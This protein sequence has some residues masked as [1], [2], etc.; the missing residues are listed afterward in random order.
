MSEVTGTRPSGYTTPI[1]EQAIKDIND[2][3]RATPGGLSLAMLEDLSEPVPVSAGRTHQA[4]P[5]AP[6]GD[7]APPPPPSALDNL[8][9]LVERASTITRT[10]VDTALTAMLP[11]LAREPDEALVDCQ[12]RG[13]GQ[14]V[15]G[16]GVVAVAALRAL[17]KLRKAAKRTR[18]AAPPPADSVSAGDDRDPTG[19]YVEADAGGTEMIRRAWACM[20]ARDGEVPIIYRQAGRLVRVGSGGE[21]VEVDRDGLRGVLAQRAQWYRWRVSL[22]G[23][24]W[25]RMAFPPSELAGIMVSGAVA[26]DAPVPPLDVVVGV[27]YVDRAGEVVRAPGYDAGSR[28]LLLPH[29]LPVSEMPPGDAAALLQDWIADFPFATGGGAAHAVGL[30][31]TPLIRRMID[32]PVPPVLIEAPKPRSGKTLLAQALLAPVLGWSAVQ[33][34]PSGQEEQEK[35]IFASLLRAHPAT[36]LDNV[37]GRVESAALEMITTAYPTV[38]G[39]PLGSSDEREVQHLTQW[40]LTT[41]NGSFTEDMIGRLV[42]I[43]IDWKLERPDLID[44]SG[45]RHP[46]IKDYTMKNRAALLS[47]LLSLVRAWVKAGRP[48]PACPAKGS[49]EMWRLVTGGILQHAGFTGFLEGVSAS[50]AEI[51]EWRAIVAVW[52]QAHGEGRVRLAKLAEMCDSRDLAQGEMGSGGDHARLIRLGAALRARAGQVFEVDNGLIVE[53]FGASDEEALDVLTRNRMT[54]DGGAGRAPLAG[55]W[56]IQPVRTIVGTKMYSLKHL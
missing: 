46:D 17:A 52:A 11:D 20:E 13:I 3:H 40:V 7:S 55:T 37:R 35:T 2:L 26:M 39:R 23:A 24:G 27:P 22:T 1:N 53:V 42:T 36:I 54:E 38:R 30:A 56:C 14:E 31:L 48:P 12:I 25:A 29:D 51:D 44:T 28:T 15:R 19:V 21:M 50:R 6:P 5:P 41:N 33:A 10:E 32:G 9:A 34:W 16:L 45:F 43:R 4:A 18:T 49:Y 8:R 47:A